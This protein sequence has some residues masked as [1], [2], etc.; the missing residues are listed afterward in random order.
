VHNGKDIEN[1]MIMEF[2]I[3]SQILQEAYQN[4]TAIQNSQNLNKAT[5]KDLDN[6][7][8]PLLTRYPAMPALT[9][10]IFSR[11]EPAL[12]PIKIPQGTQIQSIKNPSVIFQT[13]KEAILLETKKS[14]TVPAQCTT[15]G[16][17]GNIAAHQLKK[18]TQNITQIEYVDNPLPATGGT[19]AEDDEHFRIRGKN[20]KYINTKG[21]YQAI[22]NTITSIPAIK[23]Y[24]IEKM[25][26]GPGTTKIIIDP[27]TDQLIETLKKALEETKTVDEEITLFKAETIPIDINLVVNISIDLPIPPTNKEKEET[28]LLVQRYLNIYL[29][30]GNNPDGSIQKDL[31]LGTD[32]I[33][34]Q[35][36]AYLLTQLTQLKDA[37]ITYPTHPITIDS[38]Q[39]AT[40]GQ[41]NIKVE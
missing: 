30:G 1:I 18:F 19:Y 13:T 40:T 37:I 23:D 7:L 14:V 28:I 8:A 3:H 21:T 31:G 15:T 26:D 4:L 27:P 38:H 6:L 25:W 41:T 9:Q 34:S 39:K 16:P 20:W 10:L 17:S 35:A 33:P 24:Y 29:D 12:Y 36:V 5:E 22:I 2:A 32:F 11:S